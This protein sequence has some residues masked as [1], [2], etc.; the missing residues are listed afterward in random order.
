MTDE[1]ALEKHTV[2]ELK[3]I[4]QGTGKIEGLS[5]MKKADLISAIR[6]VQDEI[7]ETMEDVS[8]ETVE[9]VPEEKASKAPEESAETGGEDIPSEPVKEKP[10]KKA[11]KAPQKGVVTVS[12]LKE[13]MGVF[14]Q[15][16]AELKEKG[17]RMGANRLRR[18][19]NRL[20]K[21]TRILAR[22]AS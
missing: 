7:V 3:E 10:K 13:K 19:I 5:T 4:A 14:K 9:K 12:S 17:D 22:S 11:G 15:R 18:R 6:A 8:P 1:K 21:R 16:K 20:K 2:T